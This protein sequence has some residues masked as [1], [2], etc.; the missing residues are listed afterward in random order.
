VAG[1]LVP[2]AC[3]DA[4]ALVVPTVLA[5][6][7]IILAASCPAW[8]LPAEAVA[9]E[10]DVAECP[11][12]LVLSLEPALAACLLV[13]YLRAFLLVLLFPLPLVFLQALLALELLVPEQFLLLSLRDPQTPSEVS[14]GRRKLVTRKPRMPLP[15]RT[16]P[17]AR[18][19][20]PLLPRP[21]SA[22]NNWERTCTR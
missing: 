19:L 1:L 11:V 5:L 13:L 21:R 7:P 14:S 10:V 22:D 16:A 2:V 6:A 18:L 15:L 3:L 20:V 9:V 8:G 17:A 12:V 4:A